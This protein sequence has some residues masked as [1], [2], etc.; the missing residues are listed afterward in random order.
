M[1]VTTAEEAR[2]TPDAAGSAFAICFRVLCVI[3]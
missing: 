1:V 2:R 3:C